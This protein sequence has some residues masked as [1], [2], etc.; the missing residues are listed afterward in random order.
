MLNAYSL[1]NGDSS[2][3]YDGTVVQL[4]RDVMLDDPKALTD[5]PNSVFFLSS[6]LEHIS[7]IDPN[8]FWHMIDSKIDENLQLFID[9]DEKRSVLEIDSYDLFL[10]VPIVYITRERSVN[11]LIHFR[12]VSD[13]SKKYLYENPINRKYYSSFN[14]S[15][16]H[17][18]WL[19]KHTDLD[20][21]INSSLSS[22]PKM[23]VEDLKF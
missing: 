7:Q 1:I 8:A 14:F 6:C 18:Q 5:I 20:S 16:L 22:A 21:H 10:D 23:R 9:V 11:L 17:R 19:S 2:R 12:Q 13:K 4:Y 15:L 3:G